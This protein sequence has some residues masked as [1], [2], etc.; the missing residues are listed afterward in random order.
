MLVCIN[1]CVC[2]GVLH[3]CVYSLLT[4]IITAE[5]Y[6]CKYYTQDGCT[7]L[8]FAASN[9]HED[10]VELL[11]GAGAD[12]D[13]ADMVINSG[14]HSIVGVHT[15]AHTEY[16]ASCTQQCIDGQLKPHS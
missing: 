3:V 13:L 15:Y 12:P 8:S 2:K 10:V 11:L 9:G 4:A 6:A 5:F 14:M 16:S 7:A 1:V